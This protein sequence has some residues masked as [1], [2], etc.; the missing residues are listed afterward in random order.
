MSTSKRAAGTIYDAEE[1]AEIRT[2]VEA[3]CT[4]LGIDKAD[5][6]GR[7]RVASGI[8]RS[9]AA[10]RRTPLWLVHAGLAEAAQRQAG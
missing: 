4:E 9:W 10:G 2:A 8:M 6:A 5:T 3:V 1:L 7:E